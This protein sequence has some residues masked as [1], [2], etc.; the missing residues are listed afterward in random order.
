M[1][2]VF[3]EPPL[4]YGAVHLVILGVIAA[5]LFLLY[6][7]LRR[8]NEQT[9]VRILFGAGLFMLLAEAWKQWFVQRYV[10]PGVLSTWFFP[11]QLCSMSMYCSFLVPFLKGKAQDTVLVFLS[12]FQIIAALGA[13]LFPGDMMRPY[14][15][16]FIHS[17]LYHGLMLFESMAAILILKN[18]KDIR[19]F[20]SVLL[21]LIMAAVAEGINVVSHH[22]VNDFSLEANMF[23]ITP[24]Y[25]S[26]QPVF[27]GIALRLG[28]FPE[29]LIYL[30]VIILFS[31]GLF[32][33]EA[34]FR[35]RADA[36]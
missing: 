35:K 27:H 26:T 15:W 6:F 11:W 24:Y 5:V 9:L 33:L 22:I 28:I 1:D 36:K 14:I 20:P 32:R 2:A 31:Y 19:F 13:L 3:S 34:L 7:P 23:N 18:R 16:L 29:I 12:T 30:A 10:Y 21:F 25:P 4:P 17:F 8:Q